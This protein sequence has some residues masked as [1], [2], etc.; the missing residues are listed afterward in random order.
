LGIP[1]N[2]GE[3][4][5][6]FVDAD[7]QR[8]RNSRLAQLLGYTVT[9]SKRDAVVEEVVRAELTMAYGFYLTDRLCV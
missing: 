9:D 4:E 6:L 7:I 8:E 3:D 1:L 2:Y 5:D